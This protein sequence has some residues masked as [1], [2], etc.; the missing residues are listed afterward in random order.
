[1][2]QYLLYLKYLAIPFS[3]EV[4]A[5]YRSAIALILILIIFSFAIDYF[6]SHS[7]FGVKYRYFLAPGVIIHE[8]AHGFACFF[9][10]AKVSEMSLFE[11]NGGHVKHTRPKIPIL[12]PVLISLAPL[13]VG[14][15]VIFFASKI[16]SMGE[17]GMFK[18]GIDPKAIISANLIIV[19]N[20]FGLPL[21]NWILLYIVISTAVTMIPSRQDFVNAFFPLLILI[22][23]FLIVSKYTHIL[24]PLTSFNFLLASALNLLILMLIFSIIIFAISNIFSPGP[25]SG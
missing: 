7:I 10:G 15:F 24:L 11:K 13:I 18:N 22:I 20:L 5:H 19:H 23:G 1:M 25:H 14:I 2:Q 9:T 12:G 16:L 3:A 17:I 4:I 8:L 21:K 6:L